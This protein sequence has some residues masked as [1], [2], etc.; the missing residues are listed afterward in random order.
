[1]QKKIIL[2]IEEDKPA[3]LAK[4]RQAAGSLLQVQVIKSGYP[5][6]SERQLIYVLTGKE[7]SSDCYPSDMGYV[8]VNVA[9]AA[10]VYDAIIESKPVLSRI[11][12]LTGSGIAKPVNVEVL[13]GTPIDW[14]LAQFDVTA[15]KM[16]VVQ[17]GNLMGIT[18]EDCQAPVTKV[19][20]C[21]WIEPL[22]SGHPSLSGHPGQ[23]L[24][25]QPLLGHPPLS[26]HPEHS[27]HPCVRCGFCMDGCPVN[28][29]PQQLYWFIQGK[30]F[31][32]AKEHHLF[33]CIECGACAYV[34][35]S[36]IPLV[37]YYRQAKQ[38]LRKIEIEQQQAAAAKLRFE[39]R[40][41]RLAEPKVRAIREEK[42]N[43]AIPASV[44]SL[45]TLDKKAFL[46]DIVTKA[47]QKKE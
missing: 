21:L 47:R 27:G 19:S 45:E 42:N 15:E 17:G 39:A 22:D 14:L 12:T 4:I 33:D 7:I 28:L 13:N 3:A 30:Q 46:I 2:A 16:R 10:A 34:C 5:S 31:E 32:E 36:E 38:E 20:N 26:G 41:K 9:T 6:G 1:M 25:G 43:E 8:V 29:M 24:W 44:S 11:V 18:V 40:I 35:P 23:L 37:E